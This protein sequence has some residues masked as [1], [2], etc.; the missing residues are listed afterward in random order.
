MLVFSMMIVIR[1]VLVIRV[2]VVA[3]GGHGVGERLARKPIMMLIIVV[4]L[5]HFHHTA[6]QTK[7]KS[8]GH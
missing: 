8:C 2:T 7:H 3:G 1:C 6:A 4:T 5:F